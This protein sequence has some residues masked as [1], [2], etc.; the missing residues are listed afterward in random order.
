MVLFPGG[1]KV[2]GH[3]THRTNINCGCRQSTSTSTVVVVGRHWPWSAIV[4]IAVIGSR[5]RCC[6]GSRSCERPHCCHQRR[7]SSSLTRSIQRGQSD[8]HVAVIVVEVGR[9]RRVGRASGVS[10]GVLAPRA[11]GSLPLSVLVDRSVNCW[12]NLGEFFAPHGSA[13]VGS[14]IV[15]LINTEEWA[16]EPKP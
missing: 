5:C 12:S 6:Q 1:I 15:G 11:V 9:R 8:G 4:V 13:A 14:V 7:A 16:G 3:I 2:Y 10:G